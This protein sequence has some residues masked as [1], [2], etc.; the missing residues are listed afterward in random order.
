MALMFVPDRTAAL[1]EMARVTKPGGTV[2]VLVPS[3]L[4]RQVAFAPFV[5]VAA[6]RA[7]PK[8]AR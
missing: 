4:A 1:R 6:R 8:H 5:D 3:D 2:G 7:G